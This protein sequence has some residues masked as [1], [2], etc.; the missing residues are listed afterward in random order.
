MDGAIRA[1]V[2]DPNQKFD[3]GRW[4]RDDLIDLCHD[5]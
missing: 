5:K 1:G 2:L 4:N 3:V